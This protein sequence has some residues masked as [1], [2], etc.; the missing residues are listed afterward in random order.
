MNQPDQNPA[1]VSPFWAILLPAAALALFLGWQV[2]MAGRQRIDLL[3][4]EDQQALIEGQAVKT[5]NAL[6][7]L[8]I[9][10]MTLAKTDADA[11]TIVG[12]YRITYNTQGGVQMNPADR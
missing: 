12:K 3:R 1:T 7:R 8:T 10:L 11:R 4:I 6:Q 9:D 5:E 2:V